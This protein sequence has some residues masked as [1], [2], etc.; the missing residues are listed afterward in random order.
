MTTMPLSYRPLWCRVLR[1]VRDNKMT[2]TA[3][4]TVVGYTLI[5]LLS[6]FDLIASDWYHSI[7]GD[8]YLPPSSSYLFGTDFMGRSVFKKILKGTQVAMNIGFF[9]ALMALVIGMTLGC[10]AGYFG[11]LIDSVIVWI[12]NIL[13]AIP[14]IMLLIT[15]SFLFNRGTLAVYVGLCMTNWVSLCRL[16][17][18]EVMRHKE[19]E[20]IQA[21]TAIGA[22]HFRK[23]FIHILPNIQHIAIIRF[24]LIFQIA[25]KTEVVLSYLGIGIQ[26]MPSWGCMIDEAK[27]ELMRGCWWQLTFA[28]LAMFFIVLSFNTLSDALRDATD[29]KLKGR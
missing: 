23:I 24:S 22:G 28:T 21:A 26:D 3:L 13:D 29:P 8:E 5:A 19:Q 4:L 6:Y 12:C 18:A 20:Y 14:S 16:I 2:F 10:I 1:Y 15:I 17:R 11:G 7:S 9:V 27:T 25:I